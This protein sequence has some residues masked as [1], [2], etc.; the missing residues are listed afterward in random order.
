MNAPTHQDEPERVELCIALEGRAGVPC[1]R[2]ARPAPPFYAGGARVFARG[3]VA[4]VFL[5]PRS[6]GRVERVLTVWLGSKDLGS[7]R[8][9]VTPVSASAVDEPV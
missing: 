3:E 7:A 1:M 5:A 9:R 8:I 4:V 2:R 6:L